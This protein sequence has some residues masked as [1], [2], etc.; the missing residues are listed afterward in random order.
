VDATGR[1]FWTVFT[2]IAFVPAGLAIVAGVLD[3]VAARLLA[4]MLL[5]F[6]VLVLTPLIFASPHDH[7]SWGADAYNL[8][9]VGAALIVADWLDTRCH[10]AQNQQATA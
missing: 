2:G 8:T 9:V 4:L 3:V 10:S 5:L 6:S 7:V 1:N